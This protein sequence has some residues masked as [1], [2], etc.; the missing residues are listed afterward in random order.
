M[1]THTI[2]VI[3]SKTIDVSIVADCRWLTKLFC[4][5]FESYHRTARTG[6]A[7]LVEAKENTSNNDLAIY[8]AAARTIGVVTGLIS[9][10]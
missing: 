6:V 8:Y 5:R 10:K 7:Q 2:V 1:A 3:G 4:R 9:Q